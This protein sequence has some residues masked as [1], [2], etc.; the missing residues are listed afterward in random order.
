MKTAA[1]SGSRNEGR[2]L[3]SR[4]KDDNG[5]TISKAEALESH[6]AEP[7]GSQCMSKQEH[8][9]QTAVSKHMVGVDDSL[10]L[11][12]TTGASAV[13]ASSCAESVS[14]SAESHVDTTMPSAETVVQS[15][16][17]PESAA[18]GIV[19]GAD[20]T[21]PQGPISVAPSDTSQSLNSPNVEP[22]VAAA[23]TPPKDSTEHTAPQML[24]LRDISQD[25]TADAILATQEANV[26][27]QLAQREQEA[28]RLASSEEQLVS[29][30]MGKYPCAWFGVTRLHSFDL[31]F[32]LAHS[33]AT[34]I[35]NA[36]HK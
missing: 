8:T 2:Q 18:E 25:A 30:V 12:T 1:S 5:E 29:Q 34:R 10:P 23:Q 26:A 20:S 16:L 22:S 11:T 9:A 32:S 3:L 17:V 24:S 21:V 36:P 31:Y 28:A 13:G 14:T 7:K 19:A 33:L 15:S 27:L 35:S 6:R 4:S